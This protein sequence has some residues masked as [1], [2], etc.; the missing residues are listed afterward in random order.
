M[1]NITALTIGIAIGLVICVCMNKNMTES[2]H[3]QKQYEKEMVKDTTERLKTFLE[4]VKDIPKEI[5]DRNN[6]PENNQ[7]KIFH[8]SHLY[9]PETVIGTSGIIK[10]NHFEPY[11]K[12]ETPQTND[13]FIIDMNPDH[14]KES[15]DVPIISKNKQLKEYS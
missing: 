7:H 4:H 11:M 10:S 3:H 9:I 1:N 6:L 13:D 14:E 8:S 12:D 15:R 2:F 5:M